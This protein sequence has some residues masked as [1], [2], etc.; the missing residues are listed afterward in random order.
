MFCFVCSM[1]SLYYGLDAEINI[2]SVLS[3]LWLVYEIC[4]MPLKLYYNGQIYLIYC[5]VFSSHW[6]VSVLY[7][8]LLKV[9]LVLEMKSMLQW[10]RN[11]YHFSFVCAMFSLCLCVCYILR[12][13]YLNLL[14]SILGTLKLMINARTYLGFMM[15]RSMCVPCYVSFENSVEFSHSIFF[16]ST[17][18]KYWV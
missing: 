9:G 1:V 3:V 15:M 4:S 5:H 17:V 14:I 12:R 18:L 7:S 8:L 16:Y 6:S 11:S 2:C 10:C 13:P